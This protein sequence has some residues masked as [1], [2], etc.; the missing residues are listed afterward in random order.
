MSGLL[1]GLFFAADHDCEGLLCGTLL[2]AAD[3]SVDH[4]DAL[5]LALL[6]ELLCDCGV[7]AGQVDHDRAG[8]GVCKDT[9]LTVHIH[10]HLLGSGHADHDVIALG[11]E[12]R[13]I[14]CSLAT[15]I[16]HLVIERNLCFQCR[17][18]RNKSRALVDLAAVCGQHHGE[19]ALIE[20]VA[21]C[22]SHCSKSDKSDFFLTHDLFSSLIR[23]CGEITPR[24][25]LFGYL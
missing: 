10:L 13:R 8:T 15:I 5:L 25:S 6:A 16:E 24:L 21:H 4:L 23:E 7:A 2:A 17:S 19:A 12:F 9:F 22:K 11:K 14:S 20:A 3:G 18:E 1:K